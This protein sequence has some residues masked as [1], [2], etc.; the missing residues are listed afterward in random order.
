[1]ATDAR[2][3]W[4][5]YR[6][7]RDDELLYVGSTCEPWTR[8]R[9]HATERTW[10]DEA[11]SADWT[12]YPSKQAARD[13][14]REQIAVYNPTH[15]IQ[16][17]GYNRLGAQPAGGTTRPDAPKPTGVIFNASEHRRHLSHDPAYAAAWDELRAAFRQE[18]DY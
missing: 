7:W 18:Q 14:E 15:N 10:Y 17:W 6:L 1:M 3:M 12:G 9:S 8:F 16:R 4:W 2:A 11:N 13:A 5:V